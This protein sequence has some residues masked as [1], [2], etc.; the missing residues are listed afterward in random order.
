MHDLPSE[1]SKDV[2]C[3]VW[4]ASLD[5]TLNDMIAI[6]VLYTSQDI[7]C[8]IELTDDGGLLVREN[9]LKSLLSSVPR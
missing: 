6:L 4:L 3:R 9:V 5:R 1:G 2:V 8:L 7:L